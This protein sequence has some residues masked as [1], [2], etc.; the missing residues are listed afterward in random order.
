MSEKS[1]GD[2][3][4]THCSKL[5]VIQEFKGDFETGFTSFFMVKNPWYTGFSSAASGS[6]YIFS[7]KANDQWK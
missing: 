2:L 4:Y 1:K 6:L 5:W 7:L 3:L